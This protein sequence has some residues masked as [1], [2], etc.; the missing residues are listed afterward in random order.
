MIPR[1][2]KNKKTL[3][4]KVKQN[5]TLNN[6]NIIFINIHIHLSDIVLHFLHVK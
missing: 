6:N 2:L 1:L 3:N 4:N 5:Q